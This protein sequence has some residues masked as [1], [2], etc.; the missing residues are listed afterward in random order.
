MADFEAPKYLY[1]PVP[2]FS[3]SFHCPPLL[4]QRLSSC[5]KLTMD[6]KYS[7]PVDPSTV[8]ETGCF[9]VLRV[10]RSIKAIEDIAAKATQ[11]AV[12]YALNDTQNVDFSRY[13]MGPRGHVV[14]L[15]VPECLPERVA[16]ITSLIDTLLIHDGNPYYTPN[17]FKIVFF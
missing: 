1:Y 11:Q 9:T 15:A 3:I 14:A 5:T 8:R 12:Q 17:V 16:A 6:F 13:C 4:P 2:P 10:R 7:T